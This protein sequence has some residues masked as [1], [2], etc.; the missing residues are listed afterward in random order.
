[1][2]E[3]VYSNRIRKTDTYT[4]SLELI[5]IDLEDIFEGMKD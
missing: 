1:M 5:D 3:I 4:T 2:N